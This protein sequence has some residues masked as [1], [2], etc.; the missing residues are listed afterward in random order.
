MPAL[1]VHCTHCIMQN[2]VQYYHNDY[3]C[4]DICPDGRYKGLNG[5]EPTC[6]SCSPNCHTC[7][8]NAT[9]CLTCS[10]LG[11]LQSY[12]YSDKVCHVTCPNNTYA[13]IST[14]SC[15]DCHV[16]CSGCSQTKFN[17]INCAENY[18]R[19]FGSNQ[20]TQTCSQ[21]QYKDT[22]TKKCTACPSGCSAC[23]SASACTSCSASAGVQ[24]YL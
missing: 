7:V 23:T 4:V 12:L 10:L 18:Y 21:G 19:I 20:C 11:G 8:T 3:A 16:S 14:V 5:S 15:V 6:L 17:C 24:Y 9:N 13:E 22:I 1:A 2:S